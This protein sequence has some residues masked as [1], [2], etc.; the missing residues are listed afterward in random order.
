MISRGYGE[1]TSYLS[2]YFL[3]YIS[4]Y[5]QNS[6]HSAILHPPGQHFLTNPSLSNPHSPHIE[7]HMGWTGCQENQPPPL[8][9][10]IR[11]RVDH[12]F[13]SKC[14]RSGN[15]Q[16]VLSLTTSGLVTLRRFPGL[17][18][19]VQSLPIDSPFVWM[20]MVQVSRL[21][22]TTARGPRSSSVRPFPPQAPFSSPFLIRWADSTLFSCRLSSRLFS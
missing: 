1:E 6:L 10:Q 18:R 19:A 8:S 3:A 16:G 15:K 14:Q 11:T 7:E 9:Y 17:H 5:M 12:L 13:L 20:T 21:T 4:T 2:G 22:P